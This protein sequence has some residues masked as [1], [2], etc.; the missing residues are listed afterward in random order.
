MG[1]AKVK[2]K[3]FN[4]RDTLNSSESEDEKEKR[5]PEPLVPG[6]R[7]TLPEESLPG[8]GQPKEADIAPCDLEGGSSA[9]MGDHNCSHW[10]RVRQGEVQMA[11]QVTTVVKTKSAVLTDGCPFCDI[12]LALPQPT[13]LW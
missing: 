5:A 9:V 4:I 2:K 8:V 11:P 1:A 13:G 6:A 12:I 3:P 10:V 7:P